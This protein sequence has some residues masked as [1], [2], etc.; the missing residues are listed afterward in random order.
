MVTQIPDAAAEV[1][2]DATHTEGL[3]LFDRLT[4]LGRRHCR[5][6][7]EKLSATKRYKK[8]YK[9]ELLGV[10]QKRKCPWLN[11]LE[12]RATGKSGEDRIR[13]CGPVARSRI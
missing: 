3:G 5:L 12:P 2:A 7:S 11:D 1:D 9:R 13:T 8:R 4:G 6:S 10:T